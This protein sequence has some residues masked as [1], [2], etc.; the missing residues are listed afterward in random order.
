[1]HW[2]GA[3]GLTLIELMIGLAI[4]VVLA[5]LA[6]PS[7][8]TWLHRNRLKSA[9]LGLEIDLRE[10]RFEAV[11][12]ALPVQLSFVTGTDWCYALTTAADCDCRTAAPCRLKAVRAA[13]L[14]G[15]QLSQSQG[16]RFDPA[17]GLPEDEGA[18]AVWGLSAGERVRVSVN[19]LG[20]PVVCM[21]EGQLA[22][23]PPC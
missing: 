11:R 9:A 4:T 20:R 16:T 18:G 23:L 3:R 10:A 14:R 5:S 1:M 22:P 19:G 12:R 8:S 13:D 7:Y 21:L 2:H 15:V 6:L 17:T